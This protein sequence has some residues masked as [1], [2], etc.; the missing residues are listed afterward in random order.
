MAASASSGFPLSASPAPES[1]F[2]RNVRK[3]EQIDQHLE[4]QEN[5]IRSALGEVQNVRKELRELMNDAKQAVAAPDAS[6]VSKLQHTQHAG[7]TV[8]LN[9]G[10]QMFE[11]YI[12]TMRS[13]PNTFFDTMFSGRC[14]HVCNV[15]VCACIWLP[16]CNSGTRLS[17]SP[18]SAYPFMFRFA[19]V[20]FPDG[21]STL[22]RTA[23]TS[24]TETR[25]RFITSSTSSNCR[26]FP[27]STVKPQNCL[28]RTPS[29]TVCL[30][31][32]TCCGPRSTTHSFRILTAILCCD[33][34]ARLLRTATRREWVWS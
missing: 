23:A 14:V 15:S 20:I 31:L 32:W 27:N 21:P 6:M 3:L 12:N 24:L 33:R 28:F 7:E 30:L 5:N 19:F 10:G 34:T 9:V 22:H 11:T 18:S 17:L 26:N 13:I 8:K 1:W 2:I 16:G 29:F 25:V 4:Q